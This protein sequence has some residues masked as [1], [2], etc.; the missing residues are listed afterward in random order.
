[1]RLKEIWGK[2]HYDL[3]ELQMLIGNPRTRDITRTAIRDASSL[4]YSPEEMV[5]VVMKLKKSNIYKTAE[6]YQSHGLW[7]DFYKINDSS[8]DLLVKIQK[9]KDGSGVIISFKEDE[10]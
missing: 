7:Q 6:A 8:R 10:S 5:D 3:N 4:G 2:A 9:G 1:M